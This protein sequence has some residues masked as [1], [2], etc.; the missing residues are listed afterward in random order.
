MKQ[1]DMDE[2]VHVFG[3]IVILALFYGMWHFRTAARIEHCKYTA[4]FEWMRRH[5]G[6]A[7]FMQE[8]DEQEFTRYIAEE[9]ER[10]LDDKHYLK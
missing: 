7:P 2:V 8:K 4:L 6:Q 10:K 1:R 5:P 3:L 9:A